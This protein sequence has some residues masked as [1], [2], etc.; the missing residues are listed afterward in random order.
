MK[1]INFLILC[2]YTSTL[3]TLSFVRFRNILELR[4]LYFL[5]KPITFMNKVHCVNTMMRSL[6][7]QLHG[8][9]VKKIEFI[10]LDLLTGCFQT[11]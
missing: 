1:I 10:T 7:L 3:S 9:Q 6:H 5:F 11:P 8:I 4:A 2:E